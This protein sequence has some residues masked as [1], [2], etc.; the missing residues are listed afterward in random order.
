MCIGAIV[1]IGHHARFYLPVSIQLDPFPPARIAHAGGRINSIDYS[2]SYQALNDNYQRGFRY[3]E[4]DLMYTSDQHLVCLHDWEQSFGALSGTQVNDAISLEEFELSFINTRLTPC[5]LNGLMEWLETHPDAF[6]VTDV[7][8][9]NLA[10]LATIARLYPSLINRIVP[11]IY[12]PKNFAQVRRSGYDKV[13]WTL[14]RFP[15][16]QREI[17]YWMGKLSGSVAVTMPQQ[18]A[19]EGLGCKLKQFQVT[20]FTHTINSEPLLKLFQEQ[21]GIDEVYTDTLAPATTEV[22][23]VAGASDNSL[24]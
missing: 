21:Y 14:Y 9:N 19:K 3:F 15:A 18:L 1:L 22:I 16:S 5:T 13:I 4:I 2:N 10:A 17:L 24:C 12:T 8:E 23:T 11:Q 20:T 6:I 7:K